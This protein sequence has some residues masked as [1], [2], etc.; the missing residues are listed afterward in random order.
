VS[1]SP[2]T[3]MV[4]T[5]CAMALGAHEILCGAGVFV[6]RVVW[7]SVGAVG[8]WR[9]SRGLAGCLSGG[10][11]VLRVHDFPANRGRAGGRA[12][13]CEGVPAPSQNLAGQWVPAAARRSLLNSRTTG[14][15][16][17]WAVVP[18]EAITEPGSIYSSSVSKAFSNINALR[19]APD[20][21]LRSSG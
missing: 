20:F 8:D 14:Q 15:P 18:G 3:I 5:T 12:Q 2:G 16:P 7:E 19:S 4:I 6:C 1:I 10:S 11:V 21:N 17:E 9:P 13:A